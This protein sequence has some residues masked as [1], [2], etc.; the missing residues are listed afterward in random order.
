MT[1]TL[2]GVEIPYPR[3]FNIEPF[4]IKFADR[5][6][7]GKLLVDIIA[8]KKRFRL[9]YPAPTV[10]E[11]YTLLTL[12]AADSF[13]V[14]TY[15]YNGAPATCTVWIEQITYEGEIQDPESWQN[16]RVS[17]EEQ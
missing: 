7:S 13:V 12:K 3:D 8:T 1:W 17:L 14:F 2:G 10:L 16:V 15:T 4:D 5:A 9:F 6:A 11:L